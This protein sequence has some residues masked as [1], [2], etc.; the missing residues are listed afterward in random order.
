M[1]SIIILFSKIT[2]AQNEVALS[3]IKVR[4]LYF[5]AVIVTAII[6]LADE[7]W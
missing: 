7:Y 1:F 6:L 2:T 4:G 5:V 3:Y